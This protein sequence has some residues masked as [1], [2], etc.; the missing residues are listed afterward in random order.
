MTRLTIARIVCYLFAISSTPIGAF[1]LYL[2]WRSED[3]DRFMLGLIL[4]SV[5]LPEVIIML[6]LAH[7]WLPRSEWMSQPWPLRADPEAFCCPSCGYNMRGLSAAKCPECGL[8]FTIDQLKK[9]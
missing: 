1:G 6:L 4:F 9:G 3:H 5:A 8:E 2:M 7:K